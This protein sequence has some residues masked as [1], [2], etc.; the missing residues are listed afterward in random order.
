M[1][2]WYSLQAM[3]I[4]RN[5]GNMQQAVIFSWEAEKCFDL[6]QAPDKRLQEQLSRA[7][8][9]RDLSKIGDAESLLRQIVAE[10]ENNPER[11]FIRGRALFALGSVE[12]DA[13]RYQSAIQYLEQG[14][15]L[16][17]A[18]SA[19]EAKT[20][21][22]LSANKLSGLYS[23]QIPDAQKASFWKQR[24]EELESQTVKW[25]NDYYS[26]FGSATVSCLCSH[27]IEK[28]L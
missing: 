16:C 15:E 3:D 20:Y 10:C 25:W 23:K 19:V 24:A 13:D 18:V 22:Y 28:W 9:L 4:Q 8:A 1:G 27:R 21:A 17:N 5:H 14:Y 2:Q 26:V 12:L 6:A 11:D 7:S